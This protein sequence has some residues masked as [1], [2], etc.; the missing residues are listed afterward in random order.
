[1]PKR[2]VILKP[3]N[4]LREI[5]RGAFSIVAG[6]KLVRPEI[7]TIGCITEFGNNTDKD[8]RMLFPI[9]KI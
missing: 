1:M 4:N 5:G 9:K 2:R 3:K 8:P 6:V 7:L